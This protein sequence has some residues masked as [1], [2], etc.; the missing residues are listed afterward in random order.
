MIKLDIF[1][2]IIYN[3]LKRRFEFILACDKSGK[4]GKKFNL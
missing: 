2:I 3:K 1:K 4:Y